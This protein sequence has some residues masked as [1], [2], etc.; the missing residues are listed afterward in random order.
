MDILP[1]YTDLLFCMQLAS[2]Y[3]T[4]GTLDGTQATY[5]GTGLVFKADGSVGGSNLSPAC[6]ISLK[7]EAPRRQKQLHQYT[8]F[9]Q[10]FSRPPAQ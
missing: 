1:A 10:R 6:K 5:E 8:G 7:L 3:S 4:D 9:W 2:L